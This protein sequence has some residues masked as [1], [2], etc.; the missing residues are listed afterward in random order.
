MNITIEHRRLKRSIEGSGFNICGSK[1]DLLRIAG[2]ILR[3]ASDADF[4]FGWVEVRDEVPDQH[5]GSGNPPLAWGDWAGGT[6][7]RTK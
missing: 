6:P 5:R 4:A 3:G 1:E 2:Q 7:E